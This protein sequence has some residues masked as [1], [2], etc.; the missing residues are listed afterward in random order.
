MPAKT[1][2]LKVLQDI[3]TAINSQ[4]IT[5]DTFLLGLL[6]HG[7]HT[8]D[9]YRESLADNLPFLIDTVLSEGTC[10][11]KSRDRIRRFM[12]GYVSDVCANEIQNLTDK[13]AGYH[14]NPSSMTAEKFDQFQLA[15]VV[16]DY[17]QRAPTFWD[18]VCTGLNASWKPSAADGGSRQRPSPGTNLSE[19]AI[20]S[21]STEQLN[22][23]GGCRSGG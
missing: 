2:R 15:N 4:G 17:R 20:R 11:A 10:S 16:K 14:Y 23:A 3:A 13:K 6:E 1:V 7:H 22:Y 12:K 9:R 19:E 8:L 5:I 18:I 21:I